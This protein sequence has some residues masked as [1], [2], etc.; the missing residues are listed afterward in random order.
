MSLP[1]AESGSFS[2]VAVPKVA[3]TAVI[4]CAENCDGVV[5]SVGI[6]IAQMARSPVWKLVA[7]APLVSAMLIGLVGVVVRWPSAEP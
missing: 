1:F 4:D 5:T 3:P 6:H 2:S 7:V